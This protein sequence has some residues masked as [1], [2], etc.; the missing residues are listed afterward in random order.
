MGSEQ[1]FRLPANAP[2]SVLETHLNAHAATLL[3]LHLT[4]N[5]ITE[6]DDLCRLIMR[7]KGLRTLECIASSV[8]ARHLLR[9]IPRPLEHL[10][11]LEFSMVD[12]EDEARRQIDQIGKPAGGVFS[13]T[14]A[15]KI[16]CMYVEVAG[17]ANFD[18][19]ELFLEYCPNV[20]DLHVHLVSGNF[21]SAVLRCA[22][23]LANRPIMETFSFT[24][25]LPSPMPLEPPAALDFGH[26][27]HACAN[28]LYR[29]E[30]QRWN[31]K[32]LRDLA[33]STEP[34][35]PEPLIVVAVLE[36]DLDEQI[37][38]AALLNN[39]S[40]VHSLCLVL[41]SRPALGGPVHAAVS[42]TR[43]F[44]AITHLLRHFENLTELNVNSFHFAPAVD[45]TVLLAN[46]SCRLQA[47]SLP[48]CALLP[49]NALWRL[50]EC[51]TIE[52]LDIRS[53]YDGPRRACPGCVLGLNLN[54]FLF[55]K[56]SV[57]ALRGRLTIY[58]EF[59]VHRL[60]FLVGS[61]LAELR[62][63]D[64]SPN[65]VPDYRRLG[66]FLS[67]N[68]AVRTLVLSYTGLNFTH[69]P[70]QTDILKLSQLRYLCILS[71]ETASGEYAGG[72]VKEMSQAMK[73][74]KV[75]HL[76]YHNLQ[77]VPQQ[78]TWLLDAEDPLVLQGLVAGPP[79]ERRPGRIVHGMPCVL[80]STQT[81]IGLKRP[82][83]RGSKSAV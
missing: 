42:G 38:Q 78:L 76:H 82:R 55:E 30:G 60:D 61:V 22:N 13:D 31:C 80:C 15:G 39:W 75:L 62:I 72:I 23:V 37:R 33:T 66:W 69:R 24:S 25:E 16:R 53:G 59:T 71:E 68:P 19:L 28:V 18:L 63:V 8:K 6:A 2:A 21:N 74:L 83:N 12:E 34:A 47:L 67:V 27:A 43:L 49:E 44:H 1:N 51:R 48:P 4:N 70:F 54:P 40:A 65:P 77:D 35:L 29:R 41:L 3:E 45:L 81:F 7:A 5:R 20:I 79:G 32:R 46:C 58:S 57:S 73:N 52:D 56:L 26:C 14:V 36:N 50:A 17:D 9:V 11:R 64:K 10:T